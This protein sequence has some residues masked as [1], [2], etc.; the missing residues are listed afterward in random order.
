MFIGLVELIQ[1]TTILL[2]YPFP[3]ALCV[4]KHRK[5]EDWTFGIW[6]VLD[7]R[8]CMFYRRLD[9]NGNGKGMNNGHNAF[10]DSAHPTKAVPYQ[11]PPVMKRD[12]EG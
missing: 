1:S 12:I 11:D 5:H 4:C 9:V 7:L 8:G 10:D 6:I 2:M 3:R